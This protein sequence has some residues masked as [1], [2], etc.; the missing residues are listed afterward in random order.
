MRLPWTLSPATPRPGRHVVFLGPTVSR[1]GCCELRA[2]ARTLGLPL[3]VAGRDLEGGFDW[4]VPAEAAGDDP[5]DD[6][7]VVVAPSWVE[8]EPRHL[9][10]ALGRGV[11]VIASAACGLGGLPGVTVVPTGDVRALTRALAARVG[12]GEAWRFRAR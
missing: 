6:A 5:L 10:A 7:A 9:L 12:V 3:R 8:H 1:K 4:G 11:P 2:A